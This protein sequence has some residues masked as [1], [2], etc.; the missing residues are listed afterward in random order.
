M[1]RHL[2]RKQKVSNRR[3]KA[4]KR[5]VLLHSWLVRQG[6]AALHE[7]SLSTHGGL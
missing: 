7:L 3:G 6:K 2:S 5:L 1:S 4:K